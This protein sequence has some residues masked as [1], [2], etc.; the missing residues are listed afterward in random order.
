MHIHYL[1]IVTADVDAVCAAY[2]SANGL[3]FGE[4]DSLLGYARTATLAG[5]GIVG[6]RAPLSESE[7]PV[8]RPY[9]LVVDIEA[10]VAAAVEAGG[11]VIHEPLELP[12]RGTFAIFV[13]GGNELGLWQM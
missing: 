12:G 5:G 1:E 7:K 13:L 9:R 4:P 10:A 6:I 3:E 2:A 11:V 8:V